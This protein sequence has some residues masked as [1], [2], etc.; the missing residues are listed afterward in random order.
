MHV[1][2]AERRDSI[3]GERWAALAALT[4]RACAEV[5]RI[6]GGLDSGASRLL[7]ERLRAIQ[8]HLAEKDYT[9]DHLFEAVAMVGA[10]AGLLPQLVADVGLQPQA[11][12]A[13]NCGT[14]DP[15]GPP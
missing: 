7:I 14:E 6:L 5:E 11:S 3:Q 15:N 9:D 2:L 13:A 8:A 4:G 10:I 1:R 12:S